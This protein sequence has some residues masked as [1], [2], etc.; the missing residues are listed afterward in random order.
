MDKQPT[1]EETRK[2]YE[3]AVE[4]AIAAFPYERLEVAGD[5][6][7]A[8]WESLLPICIG[9]IG[10]RARRTNITLPPFALGATGS[11]PS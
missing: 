6:A 8:T 3:E 10:M 7:R 4:Q 9:E 1:R 5:R 2:R 11:A